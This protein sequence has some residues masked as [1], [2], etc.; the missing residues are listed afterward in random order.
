[1]VYRVP[2]ISVMSAGIVAF[3]FLFGSPLSSFSLSDIAHAQTPNNA[4]AF[5]AGSTTRTVP[6]RRWHS[7]SR[8]PSNHHASNNEDVGAPVTATDSDNDTLAYHLT[9]GDTEFFEINGSTGQIRTLKP[10]DHEDREG[11]EYTVDVTAD[12]GNG[13]T[14][15]ITVEITITDVNEAPRPEIDGNPPTLNGNPDLRG[16]MEFTIPENSKGPMVFHLHDPEGRGEGWLISGLASDVDPNLFD[17]VED[18]GPNGEQHLFFKAPPDFENPADENKDNIYAFTLL[19]YDTNPYPHEGNPAQTYP[20]VK[21]RVI[22]VLESNENP[23]FAVSE[24]TRS[25]SENTAAGQPIG[26]PVAATDEDGDTLTYSF[27]GDDADSFDIDTSTGQIKTREALDYETKNGYTVTVSVSDGK[28]E[29]NSAD[30]EIDGTIEVTIM[31]TDA[32]DPP[33]FSDEIPQDQTSTTRSVAENTEAGQLVGDPVAATDD[34]NDSLT[35]S[36]GG[37]DSAAFDFDT[38]S[39]QI[40]VRDALDYEGGTTSY[41]VTVSVYDGKDIDGNSDTTSDATIAVTIN[42]TD[43]NEPPQFADDAPATQTVDENTAAGTNIGSAYTATD[44]DAGDTLTYSLDDGDGAAFDID[45]SGQI[46]TEAALD[47]ETKPSYTVTVSVTDNKDAV[48]STD[49]TV[50]DTRTVTITVGNE[51]E[52]PTFD[53]EI[54]Q[55]QTSLSRSIPE[56]TTAGRPI[57]DPVSATDEEGD[58]LTYSVDDQ[59][60]TS[61]EIDAN[62]QIKTKDP[63]DYEDKSLYLVT[64][65]VTDSFDANGNPET[66]GVEDATIAVTINVTDVNEP[67]QFADDAPTTQ[68]VAENTAA[69]TNI[70]SAYT[71][72]D[73]ENDALT[74]TLDSGSAATFEIDANGQLKTKADLNYEVDSSY[75]VVVQVTDSKDD[76][77]VADTATDAA[78]TVT[79]TVTDEDDPGSI[80]FSSDPPIAGITLTA[81]LEDQDGVKSDVAVTWKWEISTDQTN[82]NTITD[83]ATNSYTPG[84]DDIGDYLRVTATYEDEI[85]PGKTAQTESGAILTAPP[86]NLEP[87]FTDPTANRTVAEN[88]PA[89]QPIGAPVAATHLDN[90]G[91]LTYSLGGTDAASFDIVDTTGQIQT[92][93]VLDHETKDTYSVTVSVHDGKD[94]FGNP[95][96]AADGTIDVTDMVI[97][98]IPEQPTVNATPVAAAGLTVTWPAIEPTDESPVDGY[99]VQHRVKDTTNTDPWLTTNVTVTGASATITGLAY[100]TTYEVQVRSKNVEGDSEWSPTGEGTIPSSLSVSFSSGSETVNEG[101]SATFTV[102]V[103][104]AAD[105]DLTIS[106]SASSSNAESNDYSVSG[107]PLS[108]VSGEMSKSFT[109][110]TTDDSDRNDETVNLAFGQLPAAVGTGTQSTA[111]LTI[112]DTT[113]APR[114][115]GG[116]GGTIPSSLS[117]SF[118]QAIY[119][120]T[121]GDIATITVNVSPAADRALSILVSATSSNAESGDY[122]VSGTPLA[123]A[124]G[125]A[126]KTFTVS[127]ISDS[128]MDDETVNL[129]FGQLP[130]AVVAGTQATS[131]LTIEDTTTAP[132]TNAVPEFASD[133]TTTL[134]VPENTPEGENIGDPFTATDD[135]DTTLT[136]SLDDQ[137]GA[138]F[139]VDASGQIKTKSALD[140]ETKGT[141]AVTVSVHDGRDPFGDA[142]TAVDATIDVAINVGNLDIPDPPAEP[143]VTTTRGAAA[144]LTVSWTAVT[145]TETAPVDGYD[146]QY[147]RKDATPPA[148]WSSANV[149]VTGAT[150]V[151]TGLEYGTTYEVEVRSKNSEGESDWSPTGEV[152]IP[153]RLNV[154]FSPAGRTINEGSDGTFTVNV[155]PAADRALNIPITISSSNAESGDYSPTTTTVSFA[156]GDTAKT[157]T[158]TTTDDSDRDHEALSISFGQLPTAVGTGSQSTATLTI[159]DTTPAPRSKSGGGGGGSNSYRRSSSQMYIPPPSNSA[160]IFTEGDSTHRSVAENTGSSITIGS[161]VSATDADN[162]TLIYHVGGLDGA[163]SASTPTPVTC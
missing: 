41:S 91:T 124:S 59:D 38:T 104:P 159:N 160:P 83:A 3:I 148:D 15:T 141:Y 7:L 155:D 57:G 23:E 126:S 77:G 108:F 162:D 80:T 151:I 71:A 25:V 40:K 107:T 61:F 103:S 129:A 90:V 30:E 134:F 46:K 34:E 158:I 139:E 138:S 118:G 82:W 2:V 94:P 123:F 16:A 64:V 49:T 143:T 154:S 106:V 115:G 79:I 53:E 157:F 68:T 32:N 84:S 48:G 66:P 81:V 145:A 73:P 19:I 93:E 70:G 21:V 112:N 119:T 13:G 128:D 63:L 44:P 11:G 163:S 6:E 133:A 39:G 55:G 45:S 10:P 5:D 60:G 117:V 161:P 120:V 74:Y 105:R 150:A 109:I 147:R 28:D 149:T 58:T 135:D 31:V 27:A 98:V 96:A 47:H 100:S 36:L 113:P 54:P 85:G 33:E 131:Q 99:D 130:A 67:P 136:Y 42:V 72:A 95:N 86:T 101:S 146:V 89:G 17:D 114:G 8:D 111:Q 116:G 69:D 97:P 76:N 137:D 156:S 62:G 65:S 78:I 14:D 144:G 9:G 4:P 1:M 37:T 35:Y 56:N 52:P 121:E 127:T 153:S 88:T 152:N 102:T 20:N 12:D 50:D 75:T 140:Y 132:S 22:D 142:N 110:L 87:S 24:T 51:V 26:D 18:A 29:E 43:V 92:K 122:S 125:D